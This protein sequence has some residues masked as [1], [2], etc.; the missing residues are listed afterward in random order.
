MINTVLET[1]APIA[2]T[3][4]EYEELPDELCKRVEVVDG[5]V[6]VSP[7]QTA[8]HQR[9]VAR[10]WG[11]LSA[12]CPAGMEC[13]IGLDVRFRDVPLH[14]R[15]PDL[16]VVRDPTE[17]VL[18]PEQVVLAIEVVSPGSVTTDRL[19]KR[20]EYAEA[21]MRNYWIIDPLAHSQQSGQSGAVELTALLLSRDEGYWEHRIFT[22]GIAAIDTPFPCE[23]D[24]ARLIR[25]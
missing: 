21:G 23:I 1:A 3:A 18:R 22:G 4:D 10:L 19:H 15:T 17:G 14:F 12:Q 5:Y 16:V 11:T 13:Y 25:E 7:S 24:L 6:H 8:I 20:A 2:L 9:I